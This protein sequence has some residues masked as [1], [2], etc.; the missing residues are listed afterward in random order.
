MTNG[1]T[2]D[3]VADAF[4]SMVVSL[5]SNTVTV[6]DDSDTGTGLKTDLRNDPEV[7]PYGELDGYEF[8][9]RVKA[10]DFPTVE[11]NTIV[12]VDGTDHLVLDI[13]TDRVG[14]LKVLH[15]GNVHA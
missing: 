5:P 1:L 12:D 9:V 4:D 11:I 7:M 3:S 15:L 14:A 2:S 13:R 6:T 10:S 8:S